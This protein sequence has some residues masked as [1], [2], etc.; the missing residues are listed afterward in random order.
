MFEAVRAVRIVLSVNTSPH[1]VLWN[2]PCPM[3]GA[4]ADP[5]VYIGLRDVDAG[6]KKILRDN[7]IKCFSM[8]EV[9]KYGIAKVVEMAL[10]HVS[11][12]K[13]KPIHLSF[14]VD[15]CDPSVAP[16]ESCRPSLFLVGR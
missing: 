10:E 4:Q 11:P 1:Y 13:D 8:H 5:R 2:Y 3:F 15:A 9:D 14:D 7:N 12:Q 6:E 16:S